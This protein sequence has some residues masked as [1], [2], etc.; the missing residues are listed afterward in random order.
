M[1]WLYSQAPKLRKHTEIYRDDIHIHTPDFETHKNVLDK[2]CQCL[3]EFN[4]GINLSKCV[5][6]QSTV[7]YLG[8][9]LTADGYSATN[10][11]VAT[12]LN[13]ELPKTICQLH[14]FC[15]MINF[16]HKAIENCSALLKP[17]Y[18]ILRQTQN[19]KRKSKATIID[20]TPECQKEL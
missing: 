4:L 2:I 18:K 10:K 13:Y 19:N 1:K 3:N 5:L 17:L 6:D 12:I 20:W 15:G 7:N 9:E 16:Y 11:N 8:Y 14:R